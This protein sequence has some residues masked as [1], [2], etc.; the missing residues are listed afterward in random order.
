MQSDPESIWFSS[1]TAALIAALEAVGAR[2]KAVALPPNICP[3][4]LVA[5]LAVQAEPCF[6]DIEPDRQGLNPVTLAT[7][8]ERVSCVIAVHAYGAACR[9]DEIAAIA[10]AA[11]VALIED[12]AQADG[13][14]HKGRPI[15]HHGDIAVYSFGT[16]KIVDAGGGGVAAI[17]N[18]TYRKPMI[19]GIRNWKEFDN[20]A[21]AN[22]LSSQYKLL[23]N[24]FYPDALGAQTRAFA[25]FLVSIAPLFAGRLENGR[26]S[27]LLK[28][29]QLLDQKV[30]TRRKKHDLYVSKLSGS[31]HCQC[32]ALPDGAV[33][34]RF[35]V[36]LPEGM[37]DLVFRALLARGIK[38]STWYPDITRFLPNNPSQPD[39]LHVARSFDQRL[40]NLWVDD[41]ISETQIER[42]IAVLSHE[43]E[44]VER[45]HDFAQ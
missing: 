20:S 4:V 1:G 21:M 39:L 36:L 40:L 26:E 34:W 27:H 24:N 41:S 30:A 12:C 11:G 28:A 14:T 42:S 19:E 45:Q 2:G 38:A 17:R 25:D 43:C 31:E 3:N 9:I 29:R 5:V 37:R 18:P 32:L 6:V 44:I 15:G 22:T 16:G 33:P 7:V 8:I 23:Y 35:N 13:A 10:A